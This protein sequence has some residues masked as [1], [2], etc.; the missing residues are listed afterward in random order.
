M[1]KKFPV[2][3]LLFS[4]LRLGRSSATTRHLSVLITY[5]FSIPR[6]LFA[7]GE[8]YSFGG[9]FPCPPPDR[10]LA[11]KLEQISLPHYLIRAWI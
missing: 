7:G 11:I 10:L 5:N 9:S 3:P 8:A 6:Y 4:A 1:S 2:A